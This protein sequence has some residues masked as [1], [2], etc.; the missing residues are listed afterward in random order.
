MYLSLF[1]TKNTNDK[2]LKNALYPIES[3][4][5]G[6]FTHLLPTKI[7]QKKEVKYT[8]RPM[9]PW[10]LD[11]PHSEFPKTP[12][13]QEGVFLLAHFGATCGPGEASCDLAL[14]IDHQLHL[15]SLKSHGI[16]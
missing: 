5:L 12:Q 13:A 7:H 6:I 11:H 2:S 9:D 4:G 15:K 8:N 16:S 3:M 10:V 14:S 1:S